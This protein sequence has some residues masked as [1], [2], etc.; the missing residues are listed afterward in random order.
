MNLW[1]M[2]GLETQPWT[3]ELADLPYQAGDAAKLYGSMERNSS[4]EWSGHGKCIHC[5]TA[6][7][8]FRDGWL[9]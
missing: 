8:R 1:R 9:P 5:E 6:P 7:C 2:L 3:R 4:L